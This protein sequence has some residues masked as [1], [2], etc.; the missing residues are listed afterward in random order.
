MTAPRRSRSSS[1]ASKKSA[2]RTAVAHGS[3]EK[4]GRRE[5]NALAERGTSCAIAEVDEED[6]HRL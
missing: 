2:P 5:S 6:D 4:R 1:S 3:H